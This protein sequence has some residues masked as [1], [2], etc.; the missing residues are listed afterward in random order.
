MKDDEDPG[1][2]DKIDRLNNIKPTK[3]QF[4]TELNDDKIDQDTPI[5]FDAKRNY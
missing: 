2:P 5:Q 1:T 3:R 4:K